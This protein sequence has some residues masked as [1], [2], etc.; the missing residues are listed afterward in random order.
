MKLYRGILSLSTKPNKVK[1][2]SSYNFMLGAIMLL[3]GIRFNP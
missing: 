1:F 3:T 2:F